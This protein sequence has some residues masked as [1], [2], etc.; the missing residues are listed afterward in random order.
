[1][2][3]LDRVLQAGA[4]AAAARTPLLYPQATVHALTG[5]NFREPFNQLTQIKYYGVP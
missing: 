1:M 2:L 3:S 4:A 5:I